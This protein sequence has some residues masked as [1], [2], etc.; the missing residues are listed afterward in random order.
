MRHSEGKEDKSRGDGRA[1]DGYGGNAGIA[2]RQAV[3]LES[4]GPASGCG[5]K[6]GWT[7]FSLD[8]GDE[9]AEEDQTLSVR[10]SHLELGVWRLIAGGEHI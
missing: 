4:E 8:S 10:H 2:V 7:P 6:A 1:L 9:V 3:C 5:S